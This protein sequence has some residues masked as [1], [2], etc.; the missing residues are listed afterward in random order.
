MTNNNT[1]P[2]Q[3]IELGSQL[4]I[5]IGV[6]L[7]SAQAIFPFIGVYVA[8]WIFDLSR[9]D[10]M[11][12]L[13]NPNAYPNGVITLHTIQAIGQLG[14]FVLTAYLFLSFYKKNF[15]SFL[16]L[17]KKPN[18]KLAAIMLLIIAAL[19]PIAAFIGY[20]NQQIPIPNIAGLR[21]S[22]TQL[23]EKSKHIIEEMLKMKNPGQLAY[24]LF[25]LAVVPAVSE[26]IFFRGLFQQYL[27][28]FSNKP[29]I[30][31]LATSLLF[32][33]MHFKYSQILPIFLMS[34]AL[35][36]VFYLT[37]NLLYP[38]L[39]HFL[40][41]GIMVVITYIEQSNTENSILNDQQM[42]PIAY[43]LGACVLL[44]IGYTL[45]KKNTQ[46]TPPSS[47]E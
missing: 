47:H 13:Q 25:F 35:G 41:N 1:N 24:T 5:M 11:A 32:A 2:I 19:L 23:D 14:G 42:P 20:F 31:I 17:N 45:L 9:P 39:L 33:V 12:I 44:I 6:F 21:E 29:L 30:A 8:M 7:L 38:I 43:V 26:E 3:R 37:K 10:I 28:K 27:T 36:Y 4:F 46:K 15:C 22:L 16:K 40:N 34:L 18:I